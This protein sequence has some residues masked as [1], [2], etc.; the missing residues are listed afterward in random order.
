[1]M[2]F[3]VE[4]LENGQLIYI[5]GNHED[6]MGQMLEDIQNGISSY[7]IALGMN[8][9]YSENGTWDTALALAGMKSDAA[10]TYYR[11]LIFKTR[12]SPF[13]KQL[14]RASRD[15][16]ETEHYIFVHGWIPAKSE[17][18]SPWTPRAKRFSY[19]ENWRNASKT[20]WFEARWHNGMDLCKRFGIR[21]PGKTIVCGHFHCSWGHAKEGRG[22]EWGEDACFEPYRAEGIIALDACTSYSGK[23][24][25]I[26]IED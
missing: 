8:R 6:I 25:C 20:A 15:Y 1:M 16:F 23:V 5:R 3:L 4:L 11:D 21:E 22:T 12:S 18:A 7:T 2:N 19:D 24:N 9:Y 17:P 26:V 10:L 14:M 13:Y